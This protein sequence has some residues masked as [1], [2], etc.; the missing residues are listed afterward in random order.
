MLTQR[1]AIVGRIDSM[2][3][4]ELLPM[5]PAA[6]LTAFWIL[7]SFFWGA[8]FP[9]AWYPAAIVVVVVCPLLLAA[10]WRLPVGGTMVALALLGAFMAWT[11]L[12]ILWAGAGG[13]A[14]EAT[15]KLLLAFASAFV[16]AITPWSERRAA[17]L[18]GMFAV[19]I[20]AACVATLV[21][22]S[23]AANPAS[24]FIEQRFAEPLGYAGASSAFAALAV[25]PALALAA[26]RPTPSW[27]RAAM[28]A[29]AVVQIDLMFLP[30]SRG[31]AIGLVLSA[32]AFVAIGPHRAW[33]FLRLLV[34]A[35]IAI[36]S[37]GPILDVYTAASDG[38]SV[39]GALDHAMATIGITAIV[40][41]AAGYALVRLESHLPVMPGRAT[42][43]RLRL[44]AL[45]AIVAAAAVLAIAF[46]GSLTHEASQRWDKFKAG[47]VSESNSHLISLGDPER[48]EYWRVAVQLAGE[49]PLNGVGAGNFQDE[50]TI[51]R[52][53]Q[54][55]SRYAHNIWLE[56]L[57]ETGIVGLLLLLGGLGGAV[58]AVGRAR[59]SLPP[60]TA[61]LA[62]GAVATSVYVFVH[63]SFDWVDQFP[64]I[65]GPAMA[66]LML[67][68]RLAL[69]PPPGPPRRL[70]AGLVIGTVLVGIA[71]IALVPAYLSTRYVEQAEGE[72]P[73]DA[74]A[75][76]ADLDRAAYLNPLS[77]Q[78]ELS[79]GAIAVARGEYRRAKAAF[80][81][82][83]EREDNW[84]PHFEL[85]TIAAGEGHRQAALAQIGAARRLNP[86]AY[87]VRDTMA[88]LRRRAT[89]NPARA[90]EQIRSES[91]LRFYH[92]RQP[93]R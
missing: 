92:L 1:P 26:R 34:A 3:V 91:E 60:G 76:Y 55:D 61:L 7:S 75:A 62:A 79:R 21:S 13:H 41:L 84:Y 10:G 90:R 9:S 15:N 73:R 56:T 49:A 93:R 54:K 35:T 43:R 59:R 65:L 29:V 18:L 6:A 16:F 24:D 31:A 23:L 37:V 81:E 22:A 48:Y 87:L 86:T 39:G 72:W 57:S 32:F 68:G 70:G 44:P 28:F 71:L 5:V 30:Q 85:A 14:L 50:Y 58:V 36:V 20:C 88:R 77:S 52:N 80:Q 4:R 27:L 17:L 66:F 40:A 47:E 46:G 83:I 25:W 51:H 33:A 8:Y 82:S 2:R 74:G 42:A 89:V 69:P 78:P 19:G 38:S 45:G 63:A 67:A 64:A 53:R 11:A 12:S